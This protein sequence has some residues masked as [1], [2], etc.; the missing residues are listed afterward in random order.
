MGI[1]EGNLGGHSC[2]NFQWAKRLF[3]TLLGVKTFHVNCC[4]SLVMEDTGHQVEV[5]HSEYSPVLHERGNSHCN[6]VLWLAKVQ[7]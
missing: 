2:K 4:E 7:V 3:G 5:Y 1:K 6:Q